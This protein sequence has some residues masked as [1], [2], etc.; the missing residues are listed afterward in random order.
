MPSPSVVG[1]KFVEGGN[2]STSPVELVRKAS[3]WAIAVSILLIILGVIA[4]GAPL[5]AAVTVNAIVGWLLV[6]AG[7]ARLVAAFHA[8]RAGTVVWELLVALIYIVGGGYMVFHPL[9]GV[10][11]LTL[12]LASFF[13]AEGVLE[14]V[15]YVRI[16]GQAS[17]GWMLMD[18]LVTIVLAGLIWV[19]WPSSSVWAI[20][21]I[22]GISLIFSGVKWLMLSLAS[23]K[24]L[25]MASKQPA[26][27]FGS[28][29]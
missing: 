17:A 3:G 10:A 7:A 15:S 29:A 20:G 5:I 9:L 11:T 26:T 22:V 13:L 23:R 4:I 25:S 12:L 2:M 24:V 6:F 14:V 19:P 18:G 21:T 16:R 1:K 27:K 8:S 28:A